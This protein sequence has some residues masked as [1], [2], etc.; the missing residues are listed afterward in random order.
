MSTLPI[1]TK[2]LACVRETM[3]ASYF[4]R[5]DYAETPLIFWGSFMGTGSIFAS[6]E[7]RTL[8]RAN[9]FVRLAAIFNTEAYHKGEFAKVNSSPVEIG[10]FLRSV[11]NYNGKRLDVFQ[12]LKTLQMISYN[13]DAEG[14]ME[15]E[16]YKNWAYREEYEKFHKTL[17]KMISNLAEDI[18][19]RLPQSQAAEWNL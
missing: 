10:C 11:D 6:S 17:D 8:E 13:T 7:K 19:W 14:W 1:S 5:T 15:E 16:T 18:V 9:D 2:A 3:R 12:L 4:W